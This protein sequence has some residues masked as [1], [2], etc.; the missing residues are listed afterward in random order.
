MDELGIE[1]LA[2]DLPGDRLVCMIGELEHHQAFA[3]SHGWVKSL[4]VET[5][6]MIE[7][8]ELEWLTGVQSLTLA[9]RRPKEGLGRL[10][11]DEFVSSFLSYIDPTADFR[12]VLFQTSMNGPNTRSKRVSSDIQS[13]I[14]RIDNIFA[15][16]KTYKKCTFQ[17][18]LRR[19]SEA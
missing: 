1:K 19:I 11:S 9:I 3:P 2:I 15:G 7:T 4:T 16:F 18:R 14:D 17:R 5:D 8:Y 10:N 13:D 12:V 6:M